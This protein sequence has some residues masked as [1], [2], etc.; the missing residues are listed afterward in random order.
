MKLK[1]QYKNETSLNYL[2]I[3]EL[4]K[5]DGFIEDKYVFEI[6]YS[7]LHSVFYELFG[8]GSDNV[9]CV[10]QDISEKYKDYVIEFGIKNGNP[11]YS[12]E[13]Q[14]ECFKSS[15]EHESKL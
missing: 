5:Q 7:T 10:L 2:I 3:S 6:K 14:S 15:I 12:H 1:D 9:E 13:Q 4:V 11:R 8:E